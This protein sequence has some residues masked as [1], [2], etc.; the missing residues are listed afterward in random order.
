M[1]FLLL[2][3]MEGSVHGRGKGIVKQGNKVDST[4]SYE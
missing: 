4:N 3:V 2:R 1:S